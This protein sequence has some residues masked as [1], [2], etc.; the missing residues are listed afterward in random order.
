MRRLYLEDDP[1]NPVHL[2]TVHGA[3]YKLLKYI[4]R[5]AGF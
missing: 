1:A 2:I 4:N 3:G 5:D